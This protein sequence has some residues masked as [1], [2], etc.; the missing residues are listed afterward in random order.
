MTSVERTR[1][2][3]YVLADNYLAFW[4]RFVLSNRS[5]LEQGQRAYVWDTKIHPQFDTY[6]GPRFEVACRQFIQATHTLWRHA[7]PELGVW[8]D[9]HDELDIVGHDDGLVV[10]AAEVKWTNESAALVELRLLERRVALLPRVAPDRQLALPS[11]SGFTA[12]V[13]AQQRQDFSSSVWMTCSHSRKPFAHPIRGSI[14]KH[15]PAAP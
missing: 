15:S 12:E 8:W 2:T 5:A 6:M 7:I 11:R 4:F 9:A 14:R 1:R 3:R 13:R 10:L